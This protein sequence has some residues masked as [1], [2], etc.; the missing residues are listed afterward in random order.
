MKVITQQ[1][2]N[3]NAL[4]FIVDKD[5]LIDGKITITAKEECLHVPLASCLFDLEGVNQL[6][7]FQ[8]T[9]TVTKSEEIPWDDLEIMIKNFILEKGSDHDPNFKITSNQPSKK[10]LSPELQKIDEILDHT[11]RPGLQGDGGDIEVVSLE[12][13][14]LT[15]HYEGACGTCPSA[16]GGTL[17]AIQ[18]ILR[19][20]YD[21][22]LEVS[23]L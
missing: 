22:K 3:P 8:N 17:M 13:H 18:S 5:L 20:E 21:P 23:S 12:D 15:V 7:F 1:T 11:V 19:D 14:I 10:S 16:V 6:Y 4:K 9:I 2:P